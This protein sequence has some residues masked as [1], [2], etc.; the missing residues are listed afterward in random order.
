MMVESVLRSIRALISSLLKLF[1]GEVCVIWSMWLIT[2]PVKQSKYRSLPGVGVQPDEGWNGLKCF[3]VSALVNHVFEKVGAKKSR[4]MRDFAHYIF[5]DIIPLKRNASLSRW[6][7]FVELGVGL[8]DNPLF[9]QLDA[10]L[11]C[12]IG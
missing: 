1:F 3:G 2:L 5:S 9:V 11:R 7:G 8:N 10:S 6:Q 4:E 12:M